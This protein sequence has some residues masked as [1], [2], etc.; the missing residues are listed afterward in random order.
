MSHADGEVEM[1]HKAIAGIMLSLLLTGMLT[2]AFNIQ[3]I[4][5]EPTIIVPDNWV[6]DEDTTIVNENLVVKGKIT[7]N[8]DKDLTIET[9]TI[10]INGDFLCQEQ[11]A[12]KISNSTIYMNDTVSRKF[13]VNAK[14]KNIRITDSKIISTNTYNYF[15]FGYGDM[16]FE[17]VLLQ[18]FGTS[19]EKNNFYIGG[20]YADSR[21][22]L[23]NVHLNGIAN[24][25]KFT[26]IHDLKIDGFTVTDIAP[27]FAT[28]IFN[29]VSDSYL[30]NVQYTLTQRN[31]RPDVSALSVQGCTNV[32]FDH[33]VGKGLRG[34]KDPHFHVHITGTQNRDIEVKNSYF[35]G[36]GN[37]A[38]TGQVTW[39]N[40][41]FDTIVDGV[42]HCKQG[43]TFIYDST[44]RGI[45]DTEINLQSGMT[46]YFERCSFEKGLVNLSNG[47]AIL[48]NCTFLNDISCVEKGDNRGGQKYAGVLYQFWNFS[49]L[50]VG[51][52]T[53][54]SQNLNITLR[55][56]GLIDSTCK[57]FVTGSTTLKKIDSTTFAE[58]YLSLSMVEEISIS[59]LT[60]LD[61]PLPEGVRRVGKFL[62][63]TTTH[64]DL[65]EAHIRIYYSESEL[66][67]EDMDERNLRMYFLKDP[68]SGWQICSAQGV[69]TTGN[70]VWA[71]ITQL[72]GSSSFVIG[73]QP[74]RAR[75][76]DMDVIYYSLTGLALLILGLGTFLR[77]R[78]KRA[79]M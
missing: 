43:E 73:I 18:G 2:F 69:N 10:Y 1:K 44:F 40:C 64:N 68:A 42:E 37:G 21:V 76:I 55:T 67:E 61:S 70:Y 9:S 75:G 26:Q 5:A 33:L 53:D 58:I 32:T 49:T 56:R 36:G 7:V 20:K 19:T 46:V 78:R 14:H 74:T 47:T 45:H 39:R 52:K 59:L 72:R 28:F 16:L 48:T 31:N 63:V 12:L 51:I 35:Y 6:I 34:V 66:A 71:N 65:P 22:S 57:V 24:T 50:R 62:N 23:K 29:G 4:N 30:D 79:R 54:W 17:N 25:V 27:D 60:I 38:V 77:R 41:T 13:A 15:F 3:L 8:Y 11:N